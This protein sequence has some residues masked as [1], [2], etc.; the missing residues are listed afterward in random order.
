MALLYPMT[1]ISHFFLG[2]FIMAVLTEQEC[3]S[4]LVNM[5]HF[6]I[7]DD[8]TKK[9]NLI[10]QANILSEPVEANDMFFGNELQKIKTKREYCDYLRQ[11]GLALSQPLPCQIV[12]QSIQGSD[13]EAKL[14]LRDLTI[15]GQDKPLSAQSL[16]FMK[17]SEFNSDFT[18]VEQ[19]QAAMFL[20]ETVGYDLMSVRMFPVRIAYVKGYDFYDQEAGVQRSGA[21]AYIAFSPPFV[22]KNRVGLLFTKI[23][24]SLDLLSKLK[25]FVP[26]S[27]IRLKLFDCVGV[28]YPRMGAK[29]SDKMSLHDVFYSGTFLMREGSATQKKTK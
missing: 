18:P 22:D 21:S 20:A 23:S 19:M 3:Y 27:D 28:F 6:D 11:S 4:A 16:D 9:T 29:E 8:D 1:G 25:R 2:E 17:L 15:A 24:T 5:T 12:T 26:Y 14:F 13:R 10:T 7:T